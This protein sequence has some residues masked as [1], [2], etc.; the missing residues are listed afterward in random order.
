[1]TGRYIIHT[2]AATTTDSP[3]GGMHVLQTALVSITEAIP[4]LA[5]RLSNDSYIPIFSHIL[6]PSPVF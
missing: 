4:I 6:V 2:M 3:Y 1:M 5:R